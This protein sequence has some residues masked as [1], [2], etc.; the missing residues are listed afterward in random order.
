MRPGQH[1]RRPELTSAYV[2]QSGRG[3]GVAAAA[4]RLPRSPPHVCR[5]REPEVQQKIMFVIC[6]F[7]VVVGHFS[8][9]QPHSSQ[10]C[11]IMCIVHCIPECL[12]AMV[13]CLLLEL[14]RERLAQVSVENVQSLVPTLCSRVQWNGCGELLHLVTP[15]WKRLPSVPRMALQRSLLQ[16]GN[17]SRPS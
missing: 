3:G 1:E 14:Q 5:G 9:A 6:S 16:N 11:R 15:G 17:F 13:L 12:H 4:P 8:S 10:G 2:E 7:L